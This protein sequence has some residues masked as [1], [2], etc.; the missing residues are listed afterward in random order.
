MLLFINL[1]YTKRDDAKLSFN[2]SHV[3][4]YLRRDDK[5]TLISI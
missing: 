5:S 3:T 2:T 4:L 1:K